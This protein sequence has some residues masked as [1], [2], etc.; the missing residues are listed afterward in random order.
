MFARGYDSYGGN[1][2]YGNLISIIGP[3]VPT[4]FT[5]GVDGQFPYPTKVSYG[6][7]ARSITIAW[8]LPSGTPT[9][10]TDDQNGTQISYSFDAL[11]R[12]LTVTE[13]GL[14]RTTTT[15]NDAAR[16]VT[17]KRDLETL[18]D[19]KLQ[20]VTHFDQLGR[21]RLT[22]STDGSPLGASE[23][24]G[25]KVSTTWIEGTATLGPGTRRVITSTPYR[26]LTDPTVEW[27]A[28]LYDTLG[29]LAAAST[30]KGSTVP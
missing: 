15:Y 5:Y 12:P 11:S 19:G 20:T 25:I 10:Q 3:E 7:G 23:T 16:T 24:D 1:D 18:D 22:R 4:T 8:H 2:S 9:S 21:V 13:A 17:V 14:R 30:F 26:S 6:G 29:R 28:I 27:N